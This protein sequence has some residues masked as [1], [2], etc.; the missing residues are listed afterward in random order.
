MGD[1]GDGDE[2][3]EMDGEKEEEEKDEGVLRRTD[4]F[5]EGGESKGRELMSPMFGGH[6]SCP[7]W[8]S[9]SSWFWPFNFTLCAEMWDKRWKRRACLLCVYIVAT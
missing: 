4:S 8:P 9:Q 2:E 5:N 7:K 1:H 3:E 6:S